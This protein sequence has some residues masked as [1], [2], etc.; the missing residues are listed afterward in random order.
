MKERLSEILKTYLLDRCMF[1]LQNLLSIFGWI[2]GIVFDITFHKSYCHT[3]IT[4][5]CRAID[6][7]GFGVHHIISDYLIICLSVNQYIY[8]ILYKICVMCAYFWNLNQSNLMFI[9]TYNMRSKSNNLLICMS[10]FYII[11]SPIK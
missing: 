3:L 10:R 5:D 9:L 4:T 1:D 11:F 6:V 7:F 2:G 8:K